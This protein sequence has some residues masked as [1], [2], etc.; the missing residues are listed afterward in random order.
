LSQQKIDYFVNTFVRKFE[1]NVL[2][3]TTQSE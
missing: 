2:K 3:M 1:K